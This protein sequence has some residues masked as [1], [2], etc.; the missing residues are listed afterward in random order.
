MADILQNFS[1]SFM[2]WKNLISALWFLF[3]L[4]RSI[5][6]KLVTSFLYPRHSMFSA[7]F[8]Q[9]HSLCT[10]KLCC[11]KGRYYL[12]DLWR[13][14]VWHVS[15]L[16][17]NIAGCC[18]LFCLAERNKTVSCRLAGWFRA[19]FVHDDTTFI[20]YPCNPLKTREM[21]FA[22]SHKLQGRSTTYGTFI[23]HF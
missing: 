18:S 16:P 7:I 23:P 17:L 15:L 4:Q 1:H 20:A 11:K 10:C 22:R 13:C 2:K 12:Y 9:T 21:K 6:K 14:W 5:R 3:F 19:E 8:H